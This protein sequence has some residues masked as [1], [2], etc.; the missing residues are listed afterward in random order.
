MQLLKK[1]I[2]FGFALCALGYYAVSDH[3][4]IQVQAKMFPAPPIGM[5]GAPGEGTC[6]SCHTAGSHQEINTPN[7]NPA[8]GVQIL[9]LPSA[10]VPGQTYTVTVRVTGLAPTAEQTQT[11]R[12]WG[13]EL[14]LL[15]ASGSSTNTGTITLTDEVATTLRENQVVNGQVRSYVSHTQDGTFL[16]VTESNSWFFNWTA[17]A[18]STGDITFYAAGNA[19]EGGITPE[20]DYIFTHSVVVKAPP[21]NVILGLSRYLASA[22]ATQLNLTVYGVFDSG[23]TVLF[24]GQAMPTQGVTGGLTAA[25]P[26]SALTRA[27]LFPVQVRGSGGA[28]SNQLQLALASAINAQ[29]AV[30]VDAANYTTRI[31][32]GQIAALFGTN[33]I[34]GSEA[35][36][37][38]ALPLPSSLQGTTV[39]VNGVAAR[40]FFAS[41]GQINY[42]FPYGTSTGPATVVVLRSDGLAAQGVVQVEPAVPV[43][44]AANATGSGQAAALNLDFSL[45]GDP[46]SGPQFKRVKRG[47]YIILYAAGTGAQLVAAGTTTPASL[48]DGEASPGNPLAVTAGLPVVAIGGKKAEVAFSGLAPGFVSLW[49]LNVKVPTEAP[50]GAAV[51]VLI[52]F[53][54]GVSKTLTLAIE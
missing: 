2:A 24:N 12:R 40:L 32:P 46:A 39:Y 42:Q 14:T 27:G 9:G 6:N 47:D 53:G 34:V 41:S 44:F 25:I 37:A 30:T 35:A 31:A 13:Y 22:G 23:S 18:A 1:L 49:Q 50:S 21:S 5:T 7:Y 52:N 4:N 36:S 43:L 48:S 45:N 54:G 15:N 29:A 16:G 17:P 28:L 10:Y 51:G 11:A 19:A 26:A 8:G 20:Y 3:V 33:L 38:S